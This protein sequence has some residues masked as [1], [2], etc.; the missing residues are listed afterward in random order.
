MRPEDT[1]TVEATED[2]RISIHPDDWHRWNEAQRQI[3]EARVARH[4]LRDEFA[5]AAMQ[6]E[7]ASQSAETGG[8]GNAPGSY[9]HL[10]KLSYAVADAMLAERERPREEE[11][12]DD[13]DR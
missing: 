10:A 7:L 6:G 11:G 9:E 1:I 2:G 8:Y 3:G 5:K 12:G 4:S 13:V